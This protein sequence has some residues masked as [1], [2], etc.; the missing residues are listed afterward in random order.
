MSKKGLILAGIFTTLVFGILFFQ[1]VAT[2]AQTPVCTLSL[3]SSPN[4]IG[5]ILQG[6]T[7]DFTFKYV[8]PDG[9]LAYFKINKDIPGVTF[10][11]SPQL[12]NNGDVV[13]LEV[14]ASPTAPVAMYSADNWPLTGLIE[15]G[16]SVGANKSED[17]IQSLQVMA[18]GARGFEIIE[19][20]SPMEIGLTPDPS[21]GVTVKKGDV[22]K[23]DIVLKNPG[24]YSGIAKMGLFDVPPGIKATLKMD[25]DYMPSHGNIKGTLDLDVFGRVPSGNNRFILKFDA[26]DNY[27]FCPSEMI[28]PANEKFQNCMTRQAVGR[29]KF[30]N[31]TGTDSNYANANMPATI[32]SVEPS[33]LKRVKLT[34]STFYEENSG[35]LHMDIMHSGSPFMVVDDMVNKLCKTKENCS[36]YL[37]WHQWYVKKIDL[38]DPL[39]P[40]PGERGAMVE[41]SDRIFGHGT[42]PT[43][44]GISRNANLSFITWSR[45][46]LMMASKNPPI[47]KTEIS[48]EGELGPTGDFAIADSSSNTFLVRTIYSN[49]PGNRFEKVS[50]FQ[51]R[52]DGGGIDKNGVDQRQ[53]VPAPIPTNVPQIADYGTPTAV[54]RALDGANSDYIAVLGNG[55]KN[56]PQIAS[57][58]GANYKL[59][60]LSIYSLEK[61]S[62]LGVANLSGLDS[63]DANSAIIYGFETPNGKY[64]FA[65]ARGKAP[66]SPRSEYD[67]I[68][69]ESKRNF[70]LYKLDEA[71]RKLDP[72][73]VN[74]LISEGGQIKSVA[75]IHVSGKDFLA[76]F[77]NTPNLNRGAG[78]SPKVLIYSFDDLKAG[79]VRNIA[80]TSISSM[81][82]ILRAT[83]L[84]KND[85]TYMYTIDE[86]G[87]FLI[88]KFDKNSLS[89]SGV[90]V[91]P[92]AGGG[93]PVTPPGGGGMTPPPPTDD[94]NFDLTFTPTSLTVRSGTYFANYTV[95]ANS[96]S[97]NPFCTITIIPP[98]QNSITPFLN[99][100]VVSPGGEASML[101]NTLRASEG[102]YDLPVKAYA[103]GVPIKT[104]TI[105][106]TIGQAGLTTNH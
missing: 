92:P 73:M 78:Y 25:S 91:Q 24:D 52:E 70:Y 81:K 39:S 85:E 86:Q 44:L 82:Q 57:G 104:Y 26:G 75:P 65:A 64:A 76:V 29:S 103:R 34:P 46:D 100:M 68:M 6:E 47:A 99:S 88:W 89:G 2:K 50:D 42:I 43:S 61:K 106:L 40:V 66:S 4:G 5:A 53:F 33:I 87:A 62:A 14:V 98:N 80:S 20:A 67:R 60:D 10:S 105:R 77:I 22:L 32:N 74:G 23:Y 11:I 55:G 15:Y 71:N 95:K 72:I 79:N 36:T 90:A 49:D 63:L 18:A 37:D 102:T 31:I 83:S 28:S 35:F 9:G 41:G 45:G 96:T 19:P 54:I 58:R 101:L 59:S 7:Q 94:C 69:Y 8:G 48:Q 27:S 56:T 38:A 1:A 3:L 84:I 51:I 16:C 13:S 17:R 21:S 97:V 12:P 30:F 93:T